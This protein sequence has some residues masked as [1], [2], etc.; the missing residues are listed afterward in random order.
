LM[1]RRTVNCRGLG[2]SSVS[3]SI[4]WDGLRHQY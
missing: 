1:A 3:L 4:T 2:W